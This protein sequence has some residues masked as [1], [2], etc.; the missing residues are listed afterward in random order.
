MDS[1]SFALSIYYEA[2]RI[3]DLSQNMTEKAFIHNNLGLI[4]YDLGAKDSAF[5]DF[6]KCLEIGEQLDNVMLQAI[7]RQNMGLY[8]SSIDSNDLAK[9]QYLIVNE[10]GNEFGYPLYTLSSSTNLAAIEMQA[11]NKDISDSLSSLALDIAKE[12]RFLYTVS[13]IYYGKA[14]YML[15]TN[16]LQSAIDSV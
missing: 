15:S 2:L 9:E 12:G 14:F 6:Q 5:A 7:G 3:A 13:N 11:G 1:I 16:K 8:Y 4:K 10:I